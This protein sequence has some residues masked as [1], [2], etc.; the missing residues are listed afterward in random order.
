[1]NACILLLYDLVAA[2][3]FMHLNFLIYGAIDH[4]PLVITC[5]DSDSEKE[6]TW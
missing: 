3:L 6:M 1:M 4:M 5:N 2:S